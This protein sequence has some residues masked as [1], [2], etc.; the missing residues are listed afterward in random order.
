MTSRVHPVLHS[1]LSNSAPADFERLLTTQ[2]SPPISINQSVSFVQYSPPILS[3]QSVSFVQY[4]P[5]ILSDQPVSS[6]QYSPP[7]L[8]ASHAGRHANNHNENRVN[9][10]PSDPEGKFPP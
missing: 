5:P 4:S 7:I 2:Y 3:E 1:P 10:L 8:N 9:T 6:V